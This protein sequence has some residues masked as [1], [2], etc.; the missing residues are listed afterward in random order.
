VCLQVK[1]LT[2][3]NP[4]SFKDI[5]FELRKGEILGLGGLVGAQ[6][7][8]LVESIFGIRAV[9]SGEVLVNGEP[10]KKLS[11]LNALMRA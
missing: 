1:G 4:R 2:A 11:P 9:S 3:A 6:R 5:S 10:L 8:E 7:T